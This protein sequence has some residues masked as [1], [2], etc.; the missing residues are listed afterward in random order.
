MRK[1]VHMRATPKKIL[2]LALDGK[3]R[4]VWHLPWSLFSMFC[5]KFG[6]EQTKPQ[7]DRVQRVIEVATIAGQ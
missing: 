4:E 2:V 7:Q 6:N 3:M 5:V 1:D